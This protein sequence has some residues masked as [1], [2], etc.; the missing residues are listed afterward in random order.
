VL[1]K[2]NI[3]PNTYRDYYK[4]VAEECEVHENLV[5]EL[6]RFFYSEIRSN[7]EN[8]KNTRILL[9]NLGTFIIRKNRLEKSI[10]R[11]K[12]MLGNMEKTTYT[13]YG[14]HLP[15]K[16]KLILMESAKVRVDKELK[17]KKD[18]KDENK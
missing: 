9:P 12:D 16:N 17:Q 6:V 2:N 15:V 3:N 13:G 10:K 14:N 7:L 1:K 4:D 11:H 18:W 5:S 8:L